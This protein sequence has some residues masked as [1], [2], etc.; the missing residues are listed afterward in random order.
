L[1]L[2][3]CVKGSAEP[4]PLDER[5]GRADRFCIVDSVSGSYINVIENTMRQ[6]DGS[7]GTG[8]VQLLAEQE[9]QGIV[10]PHLG[11]KAEE[12]RKLLGMRLWNQGECKNVE[13]A[14]NSWKNGELDEVLG[15][16]RPKGLFRA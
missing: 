12:A 10:A 1:I 15:K 16:N 13:E 4:L 6:A 2:A 11:P 8:A 9:V 7:A 3:F 5:F 14:I